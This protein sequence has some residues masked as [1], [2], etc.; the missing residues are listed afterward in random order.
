MS[1]KDRVNFNIFTV[2]LLIVCQIIQGIVSADQ[3][4]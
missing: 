4:F 3:G 1:T 2:A